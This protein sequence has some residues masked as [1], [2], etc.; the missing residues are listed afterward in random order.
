VTSP[1]KKANEAEIHKLA[2]YDP[3]TG[4]PNRRLLFDRIN[5]AIIHCQ[6]SKTFGAIIFLDLDRFKNIN[7]S[8]GHSI[9]DELLKE[10]S[11]RLKHTLRSEDTVARLGGD[12]FVLLL[13]SISSSERGAINFSEQLARKVL[14]SFK[15]EIQVDGHHLRSSASIGV[16]LFPSKDDT[17]EDLLR[18]ADNAMYLAKKMGRNTVRFFDPSMQLAADT[19]LELEHSLH[20]ALTN[21]EFTLFYQPQINASHQ[22]YASE[23]L[24]RW[25]RPDGTLVSPVDF[26]PICEETGLIKDV[27]TWVLNEACQQMKRWLDAGHNQLQRIAVNISA[28]QFT[29]EGFV[30]SVRDALEK[31]GLPANYLELEITESLLLEELDIVADKMQRIKSLGVRFSLDD[32]GTGYASLTYIK[33]LPIDKIKI[34]QSF[35][36]D[37][38]CNA[39]DANIVESIIAM[40]DKLKLDLIAEGVETLEQVDRL[41]EMGCQYFQGY[42]F[43]KPVPADAFI[44]R[45]QKNSR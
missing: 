19:L 11:E 18:Q 37:L 13:P 43:S 22:C 3:L 32:F 23:A 38:L 40:V 34:D 12:E 45:L 30:D 33:K 17:P 7:D 10:I 36:Q 31:S 28:L 26:I 39:D 6:R 42:Y 29:S 14:H 4:L 27:G 44:E 41:K 2:F 35:V 5:Q 15:S 8:L 16:T 20:Q 25:R 24:I 21:N 9:G 1:K